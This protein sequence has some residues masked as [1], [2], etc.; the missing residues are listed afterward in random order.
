V[1]RRF[2]TLSF[3]LVAEYEYSRSFCGFFGV[4][5]V[6]IFS[7]VNIT[8]MFVHCC[9]CV[10]VLC[11]YQSEGG[12]FSTPSSLFRPSSSLHKL[13]TS[14]RRRGRPPGSLSI[15]RSSK[16]LKGKPKKKKKRW[17]VDG[18]GS[19][20]DDCTGDPDWS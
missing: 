16:M 14:E 20:S 19:D 15:S 4:V 1:L 7:S 5:T 9:Y 10:C 18:S 12:S 8:S 6:N 2:V 11:V 13:S 3:F 17:N